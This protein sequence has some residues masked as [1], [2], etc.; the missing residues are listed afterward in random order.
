M[1]IEQK[2]QK[3]QTEL[4]LL[5]SQLFESDANAALAT[6]QAEQMMAKHRR[7]LVEMR[8]DGVDH[9]A[10][11]KQLEAQATKQKQAAADWY[12]VRDDFQKRIDTKLGEIGGLELEKKREHLAELLA[13]EATEAERVIADYRQLHSSF[14]KLYAT[15]ARKK[16]MLQ[17][18]R[19]NGAGVMG[20]PS[21]TV[22]E[23]F[24]TQ[25]RDLES[26]VFEFEQRLGL[27]PKN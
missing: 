23:H 11:M 10:E 4:D 9:Q 26:L 12:D 18:L 24:F 3:A 20:F 27:A 14:A 15:V 2:L 5:Q 7:L 13:Q 25:N 1:N 16:G 6:Q 21:F 8:L 17:L 22:G 19:L